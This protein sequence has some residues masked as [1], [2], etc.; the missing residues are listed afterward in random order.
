[1]GP[2]GHI[3]KD[4]GHGTEDNGTGREARGNEGDAQSP[5]S[6]SATSR[7]HHPRACKHHLGRSRIIASP[8]P[9]QETES[10]QREAD[11]SRHYRQ[12][13][14]K[15]TSEHEPTKLTCQVRNAEDKRDN[16]KRHE[17]DKKRQRGRSQYD[18]GGLKRDATILVNDDGSDGRARQ[19]VEEDV[20]PH[21]IE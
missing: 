8:Q 2:N 13:E 7:P 12:R 17:R 18:H 3:S 16:Q 19:N 21:P 6:P 14:R 1:M 15:T 20:P 9:G 4:D 11:W 10:G 5:F